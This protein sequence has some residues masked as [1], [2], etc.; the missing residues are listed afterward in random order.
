MSTNVTFEE[1]WEEAWGSYLKASGRSVDEV[2]V[3]KQLQTIVDLESHLD[4]EQLKFESFRKKNRKLYSALSKA[5]RPILVVS[6]IAKDSIQNT[7]VGP[8]CAIL[9][10]TMYL[11][12]SASGVSQVYDQIE[13]L[14]EK[15]Y[16]FTIRLQEYVTVEMGYSLR[17]NVVAILTCVLEIIAR[18]E[19][20]I[21]EGRFR[22]Y[23]G[24]AFVG[25]DEAIVEAFSNLQRLCD[26]EERLVLALS[27]T[28]SQRLD[29]KADTIG[30]STQVLVEKVSQMN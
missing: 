14:F 15:L 9:G 1:L 24:V 3:M 21:K 16:S 8:A 12:G 17:Q 5:I 22:K 28:T 4:E 11:V 2:Q 13:Q 7:P 23:L 20:V 29:T 26:E 27:Y 30:Q 18:S 6:S 19:K 25:K 10:A